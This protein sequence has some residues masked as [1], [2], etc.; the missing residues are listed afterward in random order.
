MRWPSTA[1]VGPR[2]PYREGRAA[3]ADELGLDPGPELQRLEQDILT[4]DPSLRPSATGSAVAAAGPVVT[5]PAQLPAGI[6]DFT[7]RDSQ[8]DQL[9][10]LLGSE[11]SALVVAAIAG[12]AG[13]GK[14]TLA[15]HVAHRVLEQFP[16]EQ[17]YV[18]LRGAEACWL[19]PAEVLGRFLRA[20][21]VEGGATADLEERS[22]LYRS[23]LHGRRVLVV[24]DNVG[25]EAQVRPL[26]PGSP[27]CAVLVTSRFRLAAKPCS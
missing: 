23:R 22:L 7:G 2:W 10:G 6:A 25:G 8:L 19:D 15:V 16:D 13:V 26:L 1:R 18:D 20:L 24:L 11:R 4:A 3:L 9:C 17:L 21:G 12:R 27:G 5:V 14:T